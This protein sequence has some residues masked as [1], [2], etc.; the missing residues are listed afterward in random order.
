MKIEIGQYQVRSYKISDLRSLVKHGNNRNVSMNLTDRFPF[1][2]RE[3]DA[4]RWLEFVTAHEPETNFAI[5]SGNEVIGGIG[6]E[7]KSDIYRIGAE[8]GY[9]V[10]EPFWGKGIAT[11]AVKAVTEYAFDRFELERIYA[12]VFH[13][14]PSSA[15]VLEKA[16]YTLEGRFRRSVIKDKKI[17][18]LLIYARLKS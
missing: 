5:A 11:D 9:W 1:P 16:G 12:G 6:F 15:R 2:Y 10:A 8:I 4:R 17:I 3:K 13:T 18:D 14:N 7:L